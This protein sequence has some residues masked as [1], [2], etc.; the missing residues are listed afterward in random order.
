MNDS[1]FTKPF[2]N[3]M[4]KEDTFGKID[5]AVTNLFDVL[6]KGYITK[7]QFGKIDKAITQLNQISREVGGDE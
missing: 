3:R 4:T 1:A 6:D 2:K 5:D 7:E